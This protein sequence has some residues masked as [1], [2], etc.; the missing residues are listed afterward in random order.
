M[1]EIVQ[2]ALDPRVAPARILTGHPHHQTAYLLENPRAAWS[3]GRVC[4][5]PRDQLTMPSEN[6]LRSDDRR[7]LR[8]DPTSEPLAED[9]Q[10][11]PFIIRHPQSPTAQ[12]S[13]QNPVFFS[14][15]LDRLL[16]LAAH[17]AG[18]S[19]NINGGKIT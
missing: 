9:R 1:T 16:L 19:P 11:A 12:L 17:P 14:E 4:P 6:R 8:Q 10:A 7:H 18:Q 3:S 15:V 2:R 5:L 13:L